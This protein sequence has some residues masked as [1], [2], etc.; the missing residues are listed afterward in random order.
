MVYCSGATNIRDREFSETK[1][2]KV[3]VANGQCMMSEGV[4]D[5]YL[6]CLVSD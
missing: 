5:G 4:G 2:E 1:N 6:Q 3:I